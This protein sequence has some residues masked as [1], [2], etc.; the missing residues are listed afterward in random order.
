MILHVYANAEGLPVNLKK[1]LMWAL[2]I[3]VVFYLFTNPAGAAAFLSHLFSGLK[4]A[5]KSFSTFANHL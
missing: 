1:I 5:G 2:V 3:F 4:S